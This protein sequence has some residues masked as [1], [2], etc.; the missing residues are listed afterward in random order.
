MGTWW[1]E[2]ST[3]KYFSTLLGAHVF[4]LLK[5]ADDFGVLNITVKYSTLTA[6]S[7]IRLHTRWLL[8]PYFHFTRKLCQLPGTLCQATQSQ[9]VWSRQLQLLLD[10]SQWAFYANSRERFSHLLLKQLLREKRLRTFGIFIWIACLLW[11][12]R[13]SCLFQVFKIFLQLREQKFSQVFRIFIPFWCFLDLCGAGQ[14]DA[15]LC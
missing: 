11:L 5:T 2:P 13:R 10:I 7:N 8:E 4:C 12:S 3:T 6:Q 9:E 14:E 15:G 1:V